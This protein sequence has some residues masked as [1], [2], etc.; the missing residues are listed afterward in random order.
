LVAALI[1]VTLLPDLASGDEASSVAL[2]RYGVARYYADDTVERSGRK[3]L[4]VDGGAGGAAARLLR[5]LGFRFAASASTT[6]AADALSSTLRDLCRGEECARE[7][8]LM[9]QSFDDA[10]FDGI[11]CGS[12]LADLSGL[13][14]LSAV[15]ELSR[16]ARST[17]FLAIERRPDSVLAQETGDASKSWQEQLA[18][19]TFRSTGG[20]PLKGV[21]WKCEERDYG[22]G[23]E[24]SSVGVGETGDV[25]EEAANLAAAGAAAAVTAGTH[26]WLVCTRSS[27]EKV[28][29]ERLPQSSTTGGPLSS[30][31]QGQGFFPTQTAP[32]V[33]VVAQVPGGCERRLIMGPESHL[34]G[35]GKM[36]EYYHFIVDFAPR[37]AYA[38][39]DSNCTKTVVY[40]PGWWNDER[41]GFSL[42][43]TPRTMQPLANIIFAKYGLT[44]S[45]YE[46]RELPN[47]V[48]EQL[49]FGEGYHLSKQPKTWLHH[50]RK[51]VT[52]LAAPVAPIG[53]LYDILIVRRGL[54]KKACDRPVRCGTAAMRRALPS[55]FFDEAE[56]FLKA[57]GL[58][59]QIVVLEE[60]GMKEQ[61]RLFAQAPVV[62]AIHGSG[63]S[64]LL[65]SPQGS[66]LVEVGVRGNKCYVTLSGKMGL[67]YAHAHNHAAD[68][69]FSSEIQKLVL[70]ALAHARITF[71]R[72]QLGTTSD[73]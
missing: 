4:V 44:L 11:I 55:A 63:L 39:R 35:H 73:K 6:E 20:G 40:S 42:H 57:H 69:G 30:G 33:A 51:H 52:A 23:A 61:V 3:F 26:A 65:F 29:S 72:T 36:W 38:L 53:S 71:P 48:A 7:G 46:K 34:S 68:K 1:A 64:N 17:L 14:V 12:G 66:A 41:F 19:A 21:G 15:A 2:A 32:G 43:D 50:F 58:R 49:D 18:A 59:Y 22:K 54:P 8:T 45:H 62:V 10:E 70:K 5:K 56:V 31:L 28:S 25:Q 27:A 24:G 37:T 67:G 16:L 9:R 47:I 60:Q 13:K